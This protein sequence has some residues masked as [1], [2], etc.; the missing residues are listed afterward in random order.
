M[1]RLSEVR[2]WINENEGMH[3]GRD[4]ALA[5]GITTHQALVALMYEHKHGRIDRTKVGTYSR[6]HR[7]E[8]Q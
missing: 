2:G 6:Y 7:K 8:Q 4:V 5:L 3:R 1:S